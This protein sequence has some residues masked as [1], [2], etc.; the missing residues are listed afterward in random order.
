[1]LLDKTDKGRDE[2]ATRHNGLPPR[3]R[4]LLLLI[5]GKHPIEELLDKLAGIG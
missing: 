1:M 5:D 2:I 3:M 4:T